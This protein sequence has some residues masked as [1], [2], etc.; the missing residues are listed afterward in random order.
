MPGTQDP[1]AVLHD[2]LEAV[3]TMHKQ[4]L[5]SAEAKPPPILAREPSRA[6]PLA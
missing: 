3:M 5:I 4:R 6:S 1:A 2:N